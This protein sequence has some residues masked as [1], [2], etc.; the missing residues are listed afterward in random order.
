MSMHVIGASHR[1]VPY[2]RGP[3]TS[4][5]SHGCVPHGRASNGR[6]P[7]GRVPHRCVRHRRA[8][9]RCVPRKC[10]CH[11]CISWV[12][13]SRACTSWVCSLGVHL[14]GLYLTG[15][16]LLG[17]YL[18]GVYLISVPHERVGSRVS[19]LLGQA[20]RHA[21]ELG[22]WRDQEAF[23]AG[24][25]GTVFRVTAANISAASLSLTSTA[26]QCLTASVSGCAGPRATT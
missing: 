16:R 5:A 2:G 6:V 21:A 3:Q 9:H 26:P 18:T 22:G 24:I 11:R 13:I 17:M 23:V 20:A 12:C 1:H 10:A 7:Y 25:H 8:S 14:V 19:E 15:L 4:S